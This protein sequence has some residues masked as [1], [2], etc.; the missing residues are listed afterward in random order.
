MKN[1]AWI[2]KLQLRAES[3]LYANTG[4]IVFS[5]LNTN[6][7]LLLEASLVQKSVQYG[8]RKIYTINFVYKVIQRKKTCILPKLTIYLKDKREYFYF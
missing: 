2:E 4:N 8:G 5:R 3:I 1:V 7:P 6:G